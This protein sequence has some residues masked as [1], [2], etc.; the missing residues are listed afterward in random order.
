MKKSTK[1]RK[2]CE[3]ELEYRLECHTLLRDMIHLRWKYRDTPAGFRTEEA[4]EKA[5]RD[6]EEEDK[7]LR[8]KGIYTLKS[9]RPGHMQYFAGREKELAYIR[10]CLEEGRGPVFLYGMGGVGKTTV[11]AAYA[12]RYVQEYENVLFLYYDGSI[13]SLMADDNRVQRQHTLVVLDN[14]NLSD[15][16]RD[17]EMQS[18]LELPGHILVAGR[19]RNEALF[20]VS[21]E[22]RPFQ[23]KEEL[24]Q[25][26]ECHAPGRL[27]G[28]QREELWDYAEKIHYLTL[29][30]V[31]KMRSL[32]AGENGIG[33]KKDLLEFKKGLLAAF[34]LKE[35]GRDREA[36]AI[37]EEMLDGLELYTMGGHV[38]MIEARELAGDRYMRNGYREKVQE[39]YGI[40]LELLNKHTFDLDP[41]KRIEKKLLRSRM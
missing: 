24:E 16:E 18:F 31:M 15:R 41:A 12:E 1:D 9:V 37:T 4:Y 11:A 40:A 22:I 35:Q 27:T 39:Q 7:R 5:L 19:K 28:T 10:S 14:C 29:P 30:L 2:S 25:L 32:G 36:L 26:L 21:L 20:P 17:R 3:K 38:E 33:W 13:R 8:E 34:H 6:W 23:E